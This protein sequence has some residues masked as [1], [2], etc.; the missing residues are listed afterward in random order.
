MQLP[1]YV[2]KGD[3]VKII[4]ENKKETHF[5][6]ELEMLP[7]MYEVHIRAVDRSLKHAASKSSVRHIFLT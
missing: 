4:Q 2:S 7:S 5:V 6:L 1:P 3:K